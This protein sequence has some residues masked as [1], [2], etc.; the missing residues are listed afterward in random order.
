MNDYLGLNC[1]YSA[2]LPL[3]FSF[4]SMGMLMSFTPDH[5]AFSQFFLILFVYLWSIKRLGNKHLFFKFF[6]TLC[7]FSITITN[8][9]KILFTTFVFE[10]KYF[11][12]YLLCFIVILLLTTIISLLIIPLII[13][14]Y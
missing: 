4:T 8:G 9:I 2:I 5:F 14:R 1:I 7:I 13:L 11:L 3:F 12:K 10:K 6:T